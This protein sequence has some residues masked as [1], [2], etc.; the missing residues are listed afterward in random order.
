MSQ[1][2]VIDARWLKTGIGRYT[3]SLLKG[4]R[5][6]L[7]NVCLTCITQPQYV[8][9]V[10]GLCQRLILCDATIYGLKEQFALPWLARDSSALYVPHYNIPVAW[11]RRLLVTIHDLNHLLDTTYRASWKSCLYARPLLRVAASNADVI[12]TPSEYTKSMLSEHLK[13]EPG[14]ISVIPG[15]VSS[16]FHRKEKQGAR[17]TVAQELGITRP[18]LLFV[19]NCAPNKNVPLLLDSMAQLRSRRADAPLLVLAGNACQW[20]AQVQAHGRSLGLRDQIVWLERIPDVL[21]AELYAAAQMTVVPSFQE[22][23]GLP[24]IES[25]ACGTPV[26]CSQ[27]ASLPEVGGDAALYFSPHSCDQLTEKIE[28][29]MDSTATQETLIAAGLERSSLFSQQRFGERQAEVIQGL[30]LN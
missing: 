22:G 1:G 16:C 14:K 4:L 15:C 17:F 28:R 18:Y 11:R 13:V 27:A 26:L 2:I 20:K 19:G 23:F 6:H 30:L 7:E 29:L 21:L 12:I 3:L 24:V 25:M 10:S 9:L 8:D 5:P